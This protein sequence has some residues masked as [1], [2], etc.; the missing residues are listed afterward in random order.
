MRGN[1]KIWVLRCA[2]DLGEEEQVRGAMN[3]K[4]GPQSPIFSTCLYRLLQDYDGKDF[5]QLADGYP[6]VG[7]GNGTIGVDYGAVRSNPKTDE[8]VMYAKVRPSTL[9]RTHNSVQ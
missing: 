2:V 1:S 4:T 8:S 6:D 3:M 9:V 5:C 7:P